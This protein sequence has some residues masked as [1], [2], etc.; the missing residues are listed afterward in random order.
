MAIERV[1]PDRIDF[2]N[3]YYSLCRLQTPS[4][5][6]GDG[7]G[8]PFGHLKSARIKAFYWAIRK[9]LS[10]EIYE[11][12]HTVWSREKKFTPKTKSICDLMAK[13]HGF[14]NY[15]CCTYGFHISLQIGTGHS[16]PERTWGF[17][18]FS[19]KSSHGF[20]NLKYEI[21]YTFSC[22]PENEIENG[23]KL[24]VS[25]FNGYWTNLFDLYSAFPTRN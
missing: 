15:R 25:I 8:A 18:S 21:P 9:L 3:E 24:S 12:I 10:G 7:I 22:T 2:P 16:Q 1:M 20:R 4:S 6:T 13:I 23:P 17:S 11:V 5:A 19:L 14:K